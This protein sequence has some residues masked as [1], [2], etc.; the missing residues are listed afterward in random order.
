MHRG[1]IW[2]ADLPGPMKRRPVLLLSRESAY[3]ARSSVT[4]AIITRTIRNIPV[5]V[6]LGLDDDMP[7]ACVVNLDNIMTIPKVE[8]REQI[9]KLQPERMIA[10][11][12]AIKFA[13]DL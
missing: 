8:L 7:A 2:W 9:T 5:E 6:T 11:V 4:V 10:V 12:E 3:G 13:L 1:E